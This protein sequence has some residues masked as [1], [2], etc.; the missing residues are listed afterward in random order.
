MGEVKSGRRVA[1]TW[2]EAS[3][4]EI[5]AALER[6]LLAVSPGS[7]VQQLNLA[8]TTG[9]VIGFAEAL[10]AAAARRFDVA[11]AFR[12][13]MAGQPSVAVLVGYPDFHLL[14]GLK[15]RRAGVPVYWVGPPQF[16][17][18][19][20]FRLGLLRRSADK[21]ACLFDFELGPLRRAGITAAY[22]G[23]PLYDSVVA[24]ETRLET[25]FRLGLQP[26][27][28]YV[29]FMPGSR[30]AEQRFHVPL[31]CRT[32]G[33]L[34]LTVPGLRGVM[35]CHPAGA[36]PDGMTMATE[37]RYD[38]IR[39]ADFA[40]IASGTATAEAAI[41]GVPHV[42]T[43]HL[44]PATR[45]LAKLV[46]RLH[47]FAIPNIVAGSRVVPEFLEPEEGKLVRACLE[48][49]RDSADQEC[50]RAGLARVRQ[51]L[52][53]PGAIAAIARDVLEMALGST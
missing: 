10:K 19:G 1:I 43:Y 2:G 5:A 14:L 11:Q 18:W 9:P 34:R 50:V 4:R 20:R 28:R 30:E 49:M 16:W 38:I 47:H 25:L 35:I 39:Q 26:D 48:L 40:V 22:Y 42:V 7:S 27:E 15:L 31:Y 6:E 21:V 12:S 8:G 17:A 36:L 53:P 41:L 29:A 3:G 33:R 37:R 52:G 23:Y 44:S 32:F 46:A 13:V 51:R 45:L 24:Q